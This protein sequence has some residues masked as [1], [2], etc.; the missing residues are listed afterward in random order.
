M[1][2]QTAR[3]QLFVISA[4]SGVG[5]TTLILPLLTERSD[6]RFSVSWTTR[7]PRIGELPGQHYHFKT[8]AEFLAGIETGRFLEWA[9]V[10]GQYYGTDGE[11]IEEWLA[12]GSDV[13]LDIDFQGARLVRC[14]YPS[15]RT[16]FI[17]PPSLQVLKERLE[18]RGTES[19]EQLT[20]RLTGALREIEEA[21][22][23]DYVI[24]N[25]VLEEALADLKAIFRACRCER[26]R[27]APELRTFLLASHTGS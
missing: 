21:P 7:A 13:L 2:P 22:W 26:S 5:K 10:H 27:K 3:G 4:P 23:Y 24:I 14:A 12:A 20:R 11:Q 9:E 19:P 15:T 8:H 1:P 16:I 17:L 6:L 18:N 25:D